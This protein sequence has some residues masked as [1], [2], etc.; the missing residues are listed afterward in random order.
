MT[1]HTAKVHAGGGES[2]ATEH[3]D[4]EGFGFDDASI[5]EGDDEDEDN[6]SPRAEAPSGGIVAAVPVAGPM[7][8]TVA[9]LI[10]LSA[11]ELASR[12]SQLAREAPP[13]QQE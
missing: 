9:K 1:R 7:S 10:G 4:E 3:S 5:E 2:T 6:D 8:L 12:N 13:S 11:R